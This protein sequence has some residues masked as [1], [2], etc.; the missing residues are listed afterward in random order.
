VIHCVDAQTG[1]AV[2]TQKAAGDIWGSALVADGKVYV[3]T[4]RGHVVTLAAGREL[5][6]ISDVDLGPGEAI[7]AT[8]VAANGVLY[9]STARHLYA[10]QRGANAQR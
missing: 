5:K 2:W 7:A 10:L 8:P 3:P 9:I 1:K 6:V 4:R